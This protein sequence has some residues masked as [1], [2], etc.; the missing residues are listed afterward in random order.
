[1]SHQDDA[2]RPGLATSRLRMWGYAAILT[3]MAF[4]QS[5]GRMVADTKFDLLTNP[6]K[7]LSNGLRLWDPTA[8]FGQVQN[9]AY[10]YAWPMGP[11]F[12]LGDLLHLPPW[13]IQRL[14]WALLICLAFFG[15]VRLAQKLALGSPLTQVLAGFAF[16]LTPRITTLLGGTSV[17][18]WPMAL[19]PWV[20]IP[21]VV[22]SERGSVR[23]AAAWSA[24]AVAC[25]GGVNA[26]AVAAV[27]PLGVI[28]ILTRAAGPRKWPL[29]GWWTLF[30]VL[31]TLWWSAPLVFVGRYSVP[32]LDYIENATI[33]TIPTDLART[34]LGQ[35]DWVAYFAGIDYPAGQQL[36]ATP[37]LVLDAA[38]VAAFGLAGVALRSNPHQ[39]FLTWGVLTGLVL[40]GFGY[41]GE[42]AGFLAADRASWLDGPLAAVRNLHK[43]DLV[44]RIPL[45]LGLAHLMLVLPSL[46][47]GRKD[48][49]S[50]WAVRLLRAAAVI[51]VV[52]MA[53][54]WAQDRI[55]PRE[56]V[57]EVPDY[58][59]QVADYLRD[60][61]DGTVSLVVPASAFGVYDW[62]N[63]HDDILQGLA[64]SP[65]AV[66]NVIPLAQ[67]GN[68]AFLDAVTRT[69]ES[70]HPSDTLAAVLAENG[71]G[72]L[73][74]R[75]DL[76]RFQTGAP[77]PAYVRTVLVRSPG[78]T[79]AKS[80]GP[81]VG[82]EPYNVVTTA[83]GDVRVVAGSGI[84]AVTGSVDVYDVEG[85]APATLT[86]DPQVLV[87][88]PGSGLQE[89]MTDLGP[90]P[91]IIAEDAEGDE[92]GQVLTDG[93]LRREVNFAAVRA[94]QSSTM[95]AIQPFRLRG[96]EHQHRFLRHPERWQTTE[97]WTGDV[98][99]V[100]ASSSQAYADA[101]APL[102][103]GA[104]P[105]AALDLDPAT[106][107]QSARNLDPTGQWWQE[108]FARPTTLSRVKIAMG[109]GS[110][111][112]EQLLIQTDDDTRVVPAP[113]PGEAR[114]FALGF[115]GAT[116]L[117]ITAAGQD[118][119]LPG[120]F[121]IAEVEVPEVVAQRVLDLPLPDERLPVDAIS[122]TR[123]PDRAVC[124]PTGHVT[125]ACDDSLIA[126]G[127][128]GDT[129]ARRFVPSFQDVYELHG[130]VSLRRTTDASV[131][132]S[133]GIRVSSDA[134]I[135][136]VAESPVALGDGDPGTTWVARR[137]DETL[138]LRFP[139]A[140]RVSSLTMTIDPGA[141]AAL[142]TK[143]KVS[144]GDRS[145][146]LTVDDHGTV[147]LPG[148]DV[149]VLSLQVRE[150]QSAFS[151]VGQQFVSLPAGISELRVNG[152]AL[153]SGP[154]LERSFPC[155][156]GPQV[157]VAGEI[158]DT[159]LRASTR[160]LIRGASVPMRVCGAAA[161]PLAA[162]STALLVPATPVFRADSVTLEA[163]DAPEASALG[164]VV[165][166][167]N[168]RGSPTSVEVPAR[169]TATVLTL[170]QNLNAG[171]TATLDGADLPA[172]RMDG[173]KQGWRL[174]AGEAGTVTLHYAPATPFVVLFAT[175]IA[176]ALLVLVVALWPRRRRSA[177]E[178]APVLAAGRPGV[179]D[180]VVVLG[181]G[182][183]LGGWWG[184]AGF[185]AAIVVGLVWRRVEWGWL[186]GLALLVG[187]LAL[188]QEQITQRSWALTWSQAWILGAVAL[189][190]AA[191]PAL[192]VRAPATPTR[193]RS[194][195]GRP[196]GR[197]PRA[198]R[199]RWSRSP[200]RW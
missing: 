9:Q 83:E 113:P 62:G 200:G 173:W 36:V 152:A 71:V 157:V 79:L 98:V 73:V 137:P 132:L 144:S 26:I 141:P 136:D 164:G 69:I 154:S 28:W 156:T 147:S 119:V 82:S 111:A 44:L 84:S 135:R 77:D 65:W 198:G 185:A 90:G 8:A 178:D 196:R 149:S 97:A 129:L 177:R 37:F 43:F 19:A 190:V 106:A 162:E 176:T 10:G 110:A 76:D 46:V 188:S 33:T 169:S 25:C 88:D 47:G 1:V 87:G 4:S 81:E 166:H 105:G 128:D 150:T 117:R 14:W 2:P 20:L 108:S 93:S 121:S 42:L 24:L 140:E 96:P 59:Y 107:W 151:T 41:S 18:I 175:G 30:T 146:V 3:A 126:P 133:S 124:A 163:R 143:V 91:R 101:Q 127:E 194:V 112:V 50:T 27:L 184:L 95:P 52:A 171:W 45:V 68:V 13:V 145:R 179:A 103:V 12:L 159:A 66:R 74:V 120:A 22:G 55:A 39:R 67:P 85:A 57:V 114:T 191:L 63:V 155:G 148:W 15:I 61:D 187:G 138:L 60:G 80:F 174:P 34:L 100:E 54:P 199:R 89:G 86:P 158:R 11:F 102:D 193:S 94:N 23:R 125:Y 186:A 131:L 168:G 6:L 56:G 99:S 104:H 153:N 109:R 32:F 70:G 130:M 189:L 115:T 165:V 16:V 181:A 64:D 53:L 161:L 38:V 118:L 122:L 183:L 134:V 116:F 167:R 51:A 192:R 35:S 180:L 172:Q 75:N 139:E 182:A 92:R 7:F 29:L 72:R 195:R 123:D 17:E 170:P 160:D 21:L 142:P 5:A 31:A 58:W 197:R 49:P 78:I 48:R 40:V